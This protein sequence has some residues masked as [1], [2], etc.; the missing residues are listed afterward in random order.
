ME[1]DF[2]NLIESAPGV[3]A[4]VSDRVYPVSAPQGASFPRITVAR[5]SGAPLYDDQGEVGLEDGRM[6]V[7]CWAISYT[8]AKR[9]AAAVKGFLSAFSGL[10]GTTTFSY[11]ML[12][13][14]RDLREGGGNSAEYPFHVALDFIVWTRG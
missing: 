14:E 8:E 2:I 3:V 7:D 10:F 6:Q 4:L 12:D 13:T 5:V 1:A 9:L 11:I